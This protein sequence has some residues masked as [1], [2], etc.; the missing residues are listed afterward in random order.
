MI[1]RLRTRDLFAFAGEIILS[2]ERRAQLDLTTGGASERIKRDLVA[3]LEQSRHE[4]QT[5]EEVSEKDIFCEIVKISYGK[6]AK[7]P[8]SGPTAFYEP[9]KSQTTA[10]GSASSADLAALVPGP[11]EEDPDM[12][13]QNLHWSVGVVPQGKQCQAIPSMSAVLNVN[14]YSILPC[15]NAL[16]S[17]AA[18]MF[19]RCGESSDAKGVRGDL[20]PRLLSVQGATRHREGDLP[21]GTLLKYS[22]KAR[23][24]TPFAHSCSVYLYCVITQWCQNS[25][26]CQPITP[27]KRA[28]TNED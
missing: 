16:P 26:V 11:G 25:R 7:N 9:K 5:T 2:A 6:G 18:W 20:H 15:L 13:Q 14:I 21:A 12:V 17:L 10:S 4:G 28:R 8:V 3:L 24:M 23:N 1:H 27:M 19:C 22:K